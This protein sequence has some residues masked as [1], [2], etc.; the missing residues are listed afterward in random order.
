MYVHNFR[1]LLAGAVLLIA[2]F[3]VFAKRVNHD[4]TP[5][6][7]DKLPF[8]ATVM[9]KDMG[10]EK[11]FTITVKGITAG[12]N[13]STPSPSGTLEITIDGKAIVPPAVTKT[14]KAGILTFTFRIPIE[15][16]PGARFGFVEDGE[17]W[18]L[19]FPTNGNYYQFLLTE[20]AGPAKK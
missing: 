17:D 2:A 8:T 4:V 13:R 16:I 5:D 18:K 7:I 20:F 3:P 11:E 15:Q 6:N 10:K 1:W 9:V 14:Q 19:P 12:P